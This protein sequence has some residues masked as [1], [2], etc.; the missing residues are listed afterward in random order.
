MK[1]LI[2]A[3]VLIITLAALCTV[4]IIFVGNSYDNFSNDIEK[5]KIEIENK[6]YDA[7]KK[8]SFDTAKSWRQKRGALSIFINHGTVEQIDESI[9][10]LASFANKENEAHFLAEC[11]IIKLNLLEMKEYCSVSLH[12]LF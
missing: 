11:E 5:C 4:S 9:T 10:Q 3:I 8:L 6:N 12:T 1:R 7:A 2:A